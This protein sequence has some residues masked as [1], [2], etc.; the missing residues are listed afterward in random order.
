MWREKELGNA[1]IFSLHR[2]DGISADLH[3]SFFFFKV[4]ASRHVV[5]PKMLAELFF[6]FSVFI[7]IFRGVPDSRQLNNLV[8]RLSY[9]ASPAQVWSY[10]RRR[11]QI[12]SCS[13]TEQK[14]CM[15]GQNNAGLCLP[16][17]QAEHACHCERFR[18][19][20]LSYGVNVPHCLCVA[21]VD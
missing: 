18:S 7:L 16:I 8:Y 4:S 20:L 13:E 1:R 11:F 12:R 19:S 10:R 14:H 21:K 2:L 3:K 5:R 6:F 9:S 15:F 17:C